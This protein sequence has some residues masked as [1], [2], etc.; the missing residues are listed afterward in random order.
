[1][2]AA[3]PTLSM[4]TDNEF[5]R[6]VT[7]VKSCSVYSSLRGAPLQA[8]HNKKLEGAILTKHQGIGLA[9]PPA[10]PPTILVVDDEP[11]IREL[12]RLHLEN[13][14]YRVI[15]APDA[16]VGGKLLIKNARELDLLIVDAHLPYM[17][18]IDFAAAVIADQTL[19]PLPIV[20]ITGHEDLVSRADLLDVPCLAKPFSTDTL[21]EVVAKSLASRPSSSDAALRYGAI[22]SLF[23]GGARTA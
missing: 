21:L 16:V 19:P 9:R 1:M 15:D 12:L 8:S 11:A 22:A 13:A 3:A 23:R 4:Y 14:G 18:G 7:F 5:A 17:T 2:K 20:L 10:K 6:P